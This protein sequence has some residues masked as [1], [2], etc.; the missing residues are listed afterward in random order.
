MTERASKVCGGAGTWLAATADGK[1]LG[2]KSMQHRLVDVIESNALRSQPP[3]EV[4]RALQIV[5]YSNTR[6][7]ATPQV[8]CENPNDRFKCAVPCTIARDDFRNYL[9]DHDRSP[10]RWR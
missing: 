5:L 1:V 8:F 4:R 9:H 6:I 10:E 3:S 7:S 2:K